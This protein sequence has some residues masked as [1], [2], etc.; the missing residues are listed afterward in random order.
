MSKLLEGI[1]ECLDINKD[2]GLASE[3]NLQNMST[4]QKLFYTQV[5]QKIG[6]NAVY[7]LRDADGIAKVPVIY[8][9]IIQQYDAN[10]IAELHRLSWNLGEAPLLFIVT[11]DEL[12]IYNNY[13]SPRV[14]RNGDLDPTAGIIETLSLADGLISQNV[15]LRK[16]HRSLLESG[17]FWRTNK[18]RFDIQGRVDSTLMSNLKI[19]RRTLINQISKRSETDIGTITRVVHALLSRSIFIKYLEERKDSNGATVFPEDFFSNILDSAKQYTDILTNKEA[20]Y[21]LFDVLKEKF[22]G[23]T[24]QVTKVEMELVSQEDLNELRLFILGDSELESRQLTLWPLY[25]FDIIPIQ[26]ISS[27]YELFFHLSDKYDEQGTYYTPLPLVDM[28]MDEVYPWEG[29]YEEITVFDPSCGSGIFLVEAYRRIICRW[30][31]Q[32]NTRTISCDQLSELLKKCIFGVDINEEAIRI[33]SFSLSLTMCDFLDPRSIWRELSFPCLIENN[34]IISD[35]FNQEQIFNKKKYDVIIGNPPWQSSITDLTKDY[36]KSVDRIIG[37]K[38]IAQA[39]SIKCSDLC[40]QEGIVCLLMPSKG[41]LF[42]R[43]NSSREYRKNFFSDNNVLAIINLS[44]YRKILFDHASGPAAAIIYTPQ[45][46][47]FNQPIIYCTPKPIYTI[48]DVR[49]FSIDPTDI[50]RLPRDLIGDDRIWK[51]AM[52]G[53]PRDLELIGKLQSTFPPMS[54]FLEENNMK[55][56]EGFKRGNRKNICNDF[57][58][59]PL[60]TAKNFKPY[61]ISSDQLDVIDFEDFECTVKK[62]REIFQAPHLIIKQSHRNGIFLSEVLDYDAVFNHSLLGIHGEISKLKYLSVIIGS[63]IFSYYHILTNRKWLVER[64]EL[65]AGDI[66]QTPIPIP[67]ENQVKEASEIFNNLIQEPNDNQKAEQ[68]VRRMYRIKEYEKYQIDDVIE[69]VYDYFKN[70]QHSI[71][72]QS[73]NI[74]IY[75]KYFRVVKEILTNTFGMDIKISG[76]LYFGDSPLSVVVI[77]IDQKESSELRIVSDNKHIRQLLMKLDNSLYDKSQMVFVRRNLRVYQNDRIYIIKPAQRKYWTYSGACRD[78]DEIFEDIS[79][80]WR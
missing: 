75:K 56:A 57:V 11:P 38:Q 43:S 61:Y 79:K 2:T 70:K 24:L 44:V 74:E 20:T 12:L 31:S 3:D 5:R 60:I 59:L 35:F 78:A 80:A 34:L 15:E 28:L 64:D 32:N 6:V 52:W 73:P 65:E 48:E 62:K 21:N 68:F 22:N 39:F 37:D 76:D 13:K 55:T 49:K 50:C 72:F 17:E 40:K 10:K 23:D 51:I 25:S 77:H 26:L 4:F 63:K 7:F 1:F 47:D 16:Y 33:A 71:S 66:W 54:Y 53:A 46:V 29:P 41:L 14:S 69:Y 27:I 42:N 30:M 58:G 9:S 8:F 36:L 18:I 45:K 67:N 19:M